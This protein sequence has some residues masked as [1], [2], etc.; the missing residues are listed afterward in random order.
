[1]I[2]TTRPDFSERLRALAAAPGVYIMRDSNGTVIYVGKA[3]K[4]KE[5][6]RSYFGSPSSLESRT[7][8]L[9][10]AIVDFEYVVTDTEQEALHLEAGRYPA[11]M[12][13]VARTEALPAFRE[14][15][16]SFVAPGSKLA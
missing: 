10:E 14:F 3:A 5:R 13:R 12:Q 2:Q 15:H 6:V 4:L 8:Y 11:L 1:M 7:R 9:A 16:Q